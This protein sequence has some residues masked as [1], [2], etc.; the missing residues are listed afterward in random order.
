MRVAAWLRTG[1]AST[2]IIAGLS[3]IA[4]ADQT[5]VRF[6]H[7]E[8]DPPS[9]EFFN[10]T[11]AEFEK[12]NPDI[13]IQMEAVSTDGRLQ[14]V[15]ASINAKTM[16]EIFKILP[17]ERTDFAH[18]GFIVP[19]DD[20][21]DEIGRNDFASGTLVAVDQKN[22]DVPYTIGNYG[23][24][25]Q[26][27]DLLKAKGLTTPTNWDELEADA[28]ALTG[29][30][31]YGFI[32]PAA[33]SRMT[34]IFFSMMMWGAG[35]T[36][37]D[38]DL[39][40]TF[41]NP[42]TVKALTFLK[43]MAA[44]SPP[45]IGSYS[46][47]DMVNVYLTG[48][49]ALDIYAPRLAANAAANTPDLME[50]TSAEATPIGPSGVGVKFANANFL[51]L[52]SPK[53]GAKNVDA[54]RKFLKYLVS[55]DRLAGLSLTAYPHMIPPLKSVQ[56]GVIVKGAADT[57]N[58]RE[59]IGRLAFDTSNSLDFE[60][61]AGAVFKDGKVIRSGVVNPYI[62]S[63]IARDIPAQVVQRVVLQ[64][65]DPAKA[66]AWGQAQMQ[67]LVNDLKK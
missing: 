2:I 20:M 9:I 42:G 63:I 16:P 6:L 38:K 44:Y 28:K 50:N 17:E 19:L 36:Y 4:S 66:A 18:K 55:G 67:R 64:G 26:R 39:N 13:K 65:D 25:W 34:S 59:A 58:G 62:G 8:T 33:K 54:A 57:L 21:I 23:V 24:L 43:R 7:N 49:I 10:R 60:T 15:L 53:I 40:V 47:N 31:T 46:Y 35:G 61:E 11:I 14:K 3:S 56:E 27:D 1:L 5:V 37:F 45:G 30:G 12:Q 51:A 32:F 22:Y 29:N 52:A 48:K 41:D